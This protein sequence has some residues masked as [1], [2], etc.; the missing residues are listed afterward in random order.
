MK[1]KQYNIDNQLFINALNS[2]GTSQEKSSYHKQ[3]KQCD[4]NNKIDAER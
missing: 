2:L 3:D 4:I 1:I